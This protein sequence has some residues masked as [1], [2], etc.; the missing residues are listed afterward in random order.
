MVFVSTN[1]IAQ[2][3]ITCMRNNV[4][5]AH[6]VDSTDSANIRVV[7]S[8]DT[9][10]ATILYVPCNYYNKSDSIV[11]TLRKRY[12]YDG[13]DKMM[14]S[15]CYRVGPHN[16]ALY[17]DHRIFTLQ[18]DEGDDLFYKTDFF[19]GDGSEYKKMNEATTF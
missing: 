19:F 11:I 1:L 17:L 2:D 12:S 14:A 5:L 9:N 7:I 10:T 13:D 3:K 8:V 4:K 6:V 16:I 18:C 15:Y